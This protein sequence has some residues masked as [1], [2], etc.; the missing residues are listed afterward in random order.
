M[1]REGIL[2]D[3]YER[4]NSATSGAETCC[5]G[6]CLVLDQPTNA[7]NIPLTLPLSSFLRIAHGRLRSLLCIHEDLLLPCD[8]LFQC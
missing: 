2:L 8:G 3:P 6:H 1:S 4:D 5:F 7:P